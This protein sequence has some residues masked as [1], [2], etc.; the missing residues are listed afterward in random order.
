MGKKNH[1]K[2]VSL[3]HREA[4]QGEVFECPRC[5]WVTLQPNATYCGGCGKKMRKDEKN[6]ERR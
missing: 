1:G 5:K 3:N 4:W 6:K 2:W